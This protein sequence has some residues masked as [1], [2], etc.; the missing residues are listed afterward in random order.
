MMFLWRLC[1]EKLREN[2]VK[3]VQ[4]WGEEEK[5]RKQVL[6]CHAFLDVEIDKARSSYNADERPENFVH[7]YLKEAETNTALE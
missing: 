4:G 1:L 6:Q 2:C 5:E 7:A 3:I